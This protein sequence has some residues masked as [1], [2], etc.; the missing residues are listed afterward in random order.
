MLTSYVTREK[1]SYFI[2]TAGRRAVL[3]AMLLLPA[4]CGKEPPPPPIPPTLVNVQISATN[5]VNA[6]QDGRGAPVTIRVY[7]LASKTTFD[8]QEFF[9]LYKNDAATLGA[10]VIKKDEFLLVPGTSKT[11][12]LKPLDP[13][14]AIGVFAGYR[15]FQNVVWRASADIPAHQTTTI[16]V[17][18]GKSGLVLDA[19]S[20]KPVSP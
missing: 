10:D 5:S 7:Q 8:G 18:A 1:A 3:G 15:D 19:K 20:V 4:A 13:V 16:T 11:L 12:N 17:T 9:T 2:R 6:M 14:R